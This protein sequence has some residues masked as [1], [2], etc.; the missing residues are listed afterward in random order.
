[1]PSLLRT[2]RRSTL[3]VVQLDRRRTVKRQL[4]R[5]V[6][7][8]PILVNVARFDVGAVGE[9][10]VVAGQPRQAAD[11]G[12]WQLLR[13]VERFAVEVEAAQR[14]RAAELVRDVQPI[15]GRQHRLPARIA[16]EV[17]DDG[18]L[19]LRHDN[20]RPGRVEVLYR[21]SQQLAAR[22]VLTRDHEQVVVTAEGGLHQ[23]VLERAELS[24]FTIRLAQIEG[25][26]A[27]VA[28]LH[29]GQD[30]A[31]G[32][33]GLQLDLGDARQVFAHLITI[34]FRRRPQRVEV[35]LLVEVEVGRR[36]FA[37]ARVARVAEALAVGRP[38]QVAA[39]RAAVDARHDLVDLL[40]RFHIVNVD[41]AGLRAAPGQRH[42]HEFA[43]GRGDVPVDGGGPLGVDLVRV[44]ED[45]GRLGLKGVRVHDEER[46]LFGRLA[47][48]GEN[49]AAAVIEVAVAGRLGRHDFR[50]LFA[51]RLG[52]GQVIEDAPGVGVLRLAPG[53][54]VLVVPVLQPAV[55][56]G[57]GDAVIGVRD[58]LLFRWGR[59]GE[60]G[61]GQTSRQ[62]Q[63]GETVRFHRRRIPRGFGRWFH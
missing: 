2:N 4:Q 56:V 31:G 28:V 1:M 6:R 11:G 35:D 52:A 39:R 23:L 21:H 51:Q 24:P 13:G 60:G 36:A 46:L 40:R 59:A 33:V 50:E 3:H 7:L 27:A 19:A 62:Q 48:H 30:P 32:V 57:D 43:V 44:H 47:A 58:W 53:F 12:D 20:R 55:I 61:P 42:G 18:V 63:Q 45:A 26:L 5:L 41:V 9:E 38:G 22:R 14:R 15:G 17:G 37:A 49:L 54:H 10:D 8:R 16:G 25:E 29:G 34:F